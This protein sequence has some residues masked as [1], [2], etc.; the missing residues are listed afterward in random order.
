MP[1]GRVPILDNS[2]HVKYILEGVTKGLSA[3]AIRKGLLERG[4]KVSLPTIRDYIKRVKKDGL[5]IS[6]FRSETESTA[7]EVNEKLKSVKGL[8]DIFNRRNFLIDTLLTRR[9]KLIE[10]AN[11]GPRTG[12]VIA[13]L[14]KLQK[15]LEKNKKTIA[16][17]D[18][19]AIDTLMKFLQKYVEQNF[20]DSKCYPSLED[21]IR[22]NTM[23]IHEICKYIEQWTSRYEVEALLEKLCEGL[24]KAA[25]NTFGPLLKKETEDE[26]KQ[27][28]E[29]FLKEVDSLMNDLRS[30]QLE[31]E[32]NKHV[33]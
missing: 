7:L 28:I 15:L 10:Y 11:E 3:P 24:T 26:R 14:D 2:I 18:Y 27:Y 17:D 12:H 22:K 29:R 20:L 6:K 31:L 33:Q 23:D 5:N 16:I 21:A 1:K 13:E 32:E 8:T 9:D 4:L 30:Y 25:V 19:L